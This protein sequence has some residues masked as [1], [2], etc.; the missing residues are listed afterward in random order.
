MS[1]YPGIAPLATTLDLFTDHFK[2]E[3]RIQQMIASDIITISPDE[4]KIVIK[5]QN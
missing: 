2:S 1:F 3:V 4:L 5:N